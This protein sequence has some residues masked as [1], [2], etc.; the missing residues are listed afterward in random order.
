MCNI[1]RDFN[2][3]TDGPTDR[4]TY[5]DATHLKIVSDNYYFLVTEYIGTLG[6]EKNILGIFSSW[7]DKVLL[8][9]ILAEAGLH[10]HVAALRMRLLFQHP[11]PSLEQPC[12]VLEIHPL[13]LQHLSPVPPQRLHPSCNFVLRSK[14]DIV[15]FKQRF[16]QGQAREGY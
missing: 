11:R 12:L 14:V 2:F 13:A 8:G 4:V 7:C 9:V 5:R 10:L 6:R 3:N 1:C 15:K 16:K